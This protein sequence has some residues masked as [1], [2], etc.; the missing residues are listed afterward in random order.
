MS[1]SLPRLATVVRKTKIWDEWINMRFPMRRFTVLVRVSRVCS[2]YSSNTV[3]PHRSFSFFT[4]ILSQVFFA[5]K[6]LTW[7]MIHD[8][9]SMI[10]C[11]TGWKKKGNGFCQKKK[12]GLLYMSCCC[13]CRRCRV[14]IH[15]SPTYSS[16][17][18]RP[19]FAY[20]WFFP[21]FFSQ[22]RKEKQGVRCGIR[23]SINTSISSGAGTSCSYST[24][25][26]CD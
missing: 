26:Y 24:V 25:V 7:S 6:F 23:C 16:P 3:V 18:R 8:P 9:W 20:T 12:Q 21:L 5:F 15:R 19:I 11:S 14:R 2:M 1:L 4:L 10:F 13:C 17:T 22:K